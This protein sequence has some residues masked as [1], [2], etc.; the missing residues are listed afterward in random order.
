MDK[1]RRLQ[2]PSIRVLALYAATVLAEVPV[3]FL[4]MLLTL[5]VAVI[6]LLLKGDST[7]GA[8]G[9]AELA[10]IPTG[11]SILALLTPLGVAGGG[12]RTW[13]DATPHSASKPPTKKPSNSPSQAPRGPS[14]CRACG[15]C[16]TRHSQTP[17]SAGT[18]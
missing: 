16:L 2:F 12:R 3:I 1:C 5:A 18:R 4:R 10:L 8:E 13:A 9:I 11:W 17:R 6:V 7:G 15:S 14:G